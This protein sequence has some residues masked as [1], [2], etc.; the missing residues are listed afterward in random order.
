MN[1]SLFH[2]DLRWAV[3]C[4]SAWVVLF[5]VAVA[6]TG[7]AQP[8]FSFGA[9]ADCQYADQPETNR[10]YRQ[11]IRK[12]TDCVTALNQKELAFV[13]HLGDFIDKDWKSFDS[14]SPIF[15][16]LKAPRYHVLGN[17]DF[18]VADERKKDVPARLKMK[19]RYYDFT[20]GG[21]RFIVLDGNDISLIAYPKGSDAYKRAAA[22][23]RALKR[24]SPSWNGALG[25]TQVKWLEATLTQADKA[26]EKA[27]L[28]CH[29]P[30]YPANNHNLWNDSKVG[31]IIDRHRSVVA[32]IN[33]H[34][35]AGNYGQRNGVHYL[36]LKGMV[37]TTE[38]AYSVIEVYRDRL[39]V[40]GFGRQERRTLKLS[41]K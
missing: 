20:H 28:F 16:R 12:L 6:E 24:P 40:V 21:F 15:E 13:V 23:H 17:H 39:E 22:F 1:Y 25:D 10:K 2:R 5:I 27:V 37:D 30:V 36:T 18:S 19:S 11:S 14:V 9:I 31:Q 38:S 4:R 35:H 34:N 32:Y 26:G 33:G 29:F 8:L 7:W 41:A 3:R